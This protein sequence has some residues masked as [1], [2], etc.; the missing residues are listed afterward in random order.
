M[1]TLKNLR[2]SFDNNEI[3]KGINLTVNKGDV[4]TFIGP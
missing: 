4:V 2:I 1:L 3:L